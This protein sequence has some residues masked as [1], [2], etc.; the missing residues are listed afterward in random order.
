MQAMAHRVTRAA[1][2]YAKGNRQVSHVIEMANQRVK[3]VLEFVG[4]RRAE[5]EAMVEAI[6]TIGQIGLDNQDA[7]HRTAGAI[8]GLLDAAS[9]LEEHVSRFKLTKENA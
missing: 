8:N 5:S 3:D 1:A 2:E 4:K 9:R 7:M 6:R